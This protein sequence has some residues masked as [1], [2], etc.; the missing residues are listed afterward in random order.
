MDWWKSLAQAF[1]DNGRP[2]WAARATQIAERCDEMIT[3]WEQWE[4][5]RQ[6]RQDRVKGDHNGDGHPDNGWHQRG[7]RDD[8]DRGD[9][10]RD[11]R[12][13]RPQAQKA[14]RHREGR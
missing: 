8:D 10:D 14:S 7:D 2:D 4:E 5:R 12:R 9:D 3:R 1:A 13:G 6:E 11:G